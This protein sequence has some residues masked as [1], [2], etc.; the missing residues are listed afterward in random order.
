MGAVLTPQA[1]KPM[2]ENAAFHKR[3]EL[4]CDKLRQACSSRSTVPAACNAGK[5]ERYWAL[6]YGRSP[7]R[8]IFL[9]PE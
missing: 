5:P 3:L 4:A 9:N 2:S 8:M 1:Q 6:Q 7:W